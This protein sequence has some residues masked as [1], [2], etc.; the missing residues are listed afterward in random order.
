MIAEPACR[1]AAGGTRELIDR[2]SFEIRFH[3]GSPLSF[4][5]APRAPAPRTSAI[6]DMRVRRRQ[7]ESANR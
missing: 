3:G 1:D 4:A 6:D 2:Q 5:F 7:L